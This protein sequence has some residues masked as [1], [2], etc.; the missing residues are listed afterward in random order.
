VGDADAHFAVR[1]VAQ[2]AQQAL[3]QAQGQLQAHGFVGVVQQRP[4]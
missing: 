3:W 4:G 2:V 1:V